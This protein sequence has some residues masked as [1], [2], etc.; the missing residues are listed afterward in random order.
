VVMVNGRGGG[1]NNGTHI[2]GTNIVSFLFFSLELIG[3]KSVVINMRREWWWS[4]S[5]LSF[6]SF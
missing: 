5:N 2:N 6:P 4:T 1:Q 3:L